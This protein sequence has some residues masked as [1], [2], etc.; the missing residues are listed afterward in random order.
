MD[1]NPRHV[2]RM[3]LHPV[4]PIHAPLHRKCPINAFAPMNNITYRL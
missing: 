3:K 4:R 1:C 2:N